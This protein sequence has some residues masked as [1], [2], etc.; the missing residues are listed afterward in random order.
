MSNFDS[1]LAL[2]LGLTVACALASGLAAGGAVATL[3]ANATI[4]GDTNDL[5]NFGAGM[6]AAAAGALAAMVAYGTVTVVGVRWLVGEGRRGATTTALLLGPV[7]LLF[8][9]RLAPL[10]SAVTT[11]S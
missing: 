9:A 5:S 10:L 2:R 8:A 1:R 6:T 7:F 3:V 4:S 11:A